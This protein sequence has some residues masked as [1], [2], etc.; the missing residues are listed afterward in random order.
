[1]VMYCYCFE[2]GCVRVEKSGG[3]VDVHAP[4]VISAAGI[5]NTFERLLNEKKPTADKALLKTKAVRH[6]FGA[7]SV[8]VGLKGTKEEFGLKATN[9][10]AFTDNDL[11]KSTREFLELDAATAGTTDVPI[12]F[13]SFPSTKDPEWENRHPGKTTCTIITLAP[14]EWFERW[15]NERVMKRGEEY[16]EIKNRIGKR[17]WEQTC[18]FFP[19]VRDRVDFFDVGSPLSNRY[20]IAAPRGE[21]YG[22]D[23]HVDRFSPWAAIKLRP[24]TSI[25]GLY[26]SG[27][28]ILSCGFA[29]AM[30]SGVI[31]A[32][33][34]LK[35]NVF[36]DMS[37]LQKELKKKKPPTGGAVENGAVQN[38][39]VKPDD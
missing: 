30:S 12:L 28:D 24:N 7:M 19:Q 38:G 34:V 3:D 37:R 32:S 2:L 27:Q 18:K 13:I 26:L 23:H 15:E 14:Y 20:Y 31:T 22:I 11:D 8:Y 29:G 1:M 39:S 5:Y 9:V 6:G 36:A 17:I 4:V 35:R 33:A 25:P 21:I 10:W 16:E